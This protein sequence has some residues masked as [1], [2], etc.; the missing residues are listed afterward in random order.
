MGGDVILSS[1]LGEMF[2]TEGGNGIWLIFCGTGFRR[3]AMRDLG[4]VSVVSG[5][6]WMGGCLRMM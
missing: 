6:F 1:Y 4:V 3:S 2:Q 5:N